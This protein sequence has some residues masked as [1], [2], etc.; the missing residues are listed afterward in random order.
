MDDLRVVVRLLRRQ[1]Q[2]AEQIG[3]AEDARER[4][5]QVVADVGNQLALHALRAHLILKR[6]LH[7]IVKT[8]SDKQKHKEGKRA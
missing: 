1:L 4:R 2:L 8:G 5:F 6:R 7:R 3:I